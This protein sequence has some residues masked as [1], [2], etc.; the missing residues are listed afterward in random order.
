M[1][2]HMI[3]D[4]PTPCKKR[5]HCEETSN[6][7]SRGRRVRRKEIHNV[8]LADD[9]NTTALMMNE[10][11]IGKS[12]P[13][14]G[15]KKLKLKKTGVFKRDTGTFGKN[16]TSVLTFGEDMFGQIGLGEGVSRKRPASIIGLENF[17]RVSC[18]GQHTL[19]VNRDGEVWGFGNNEN[20]SLGEGGEGED[21]F[22]VPTQIKGFVPSKHKGESHGYNL[23]SMKA[24]C[25]VHTCEERIVDVSACDTGSL[26]LSEEGNVYFFGSYYDSVR[27]KAFKHVS[28]P[29]DARRMQKDHGLGNGDNIY[30]T[31]GCQYHPVHLYQNLEGKVRQIDSG[32]TFAAVVMETID[33]NNDVKNVCMTWGVGESGSEFL[34]A[35]HAEETGVINETSDEYLVPTQVKFEDNQI[36]DV[37]AVACG[38]AHLLVIARDKSGDNMGKSA[39]YGCGLNRDGQLGLGHT[40]NVNRMKKVNAITLCAN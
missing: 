11:S 15:L 17:Q 10:F 9:F 24:A 38:S 31:K 35:I 7:A 8:K 28:A 36:H 6:D 4:M 18:G 12:N 20:G 32:S 25:R 5:K 13:S 40:S 21:I 37:D 2:Q 34:P 33:C 19:V 26:A 30:T 3:I 39:V 29:D 16:Y 22:F 23:R 14:N 1:P 27:G